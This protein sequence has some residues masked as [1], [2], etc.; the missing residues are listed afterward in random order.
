[1]KKLSIGIKETDVILI[2]RG[3]NNTSSMIVINPSD[4]HFLE[5]DLSGINLL[6][7]NKEKIRRIHLQGFCISEICEATSLLNLSLYKM[8]Q[9]EFP[10]TDDLRIIKRRQFSISFLYKVKKFLHFKFCV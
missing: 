10:I 4:V 9:R 6:N 1:M 2:K 8:R 5:W 7:K 3:E